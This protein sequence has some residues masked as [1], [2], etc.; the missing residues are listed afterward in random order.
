MKALL[1]KPRGRFI[2][3]LR[4]VWLVRG[5]GLYAFGFIATFVLLELQSLA[6]DVLGIGSLF[7][8]QAVEFLVQFVLD[9]L[10]NTFRSFVW[11]VFILQIAPPFGAIALA[12]AFLW[13]ARFLKR[14]IETWLFP[15]GVP[16]SRKK[17]KSAL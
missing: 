11:P 13:F 7:N 17:K 5:G 2:E 4:K 8:G 12:L 15:D 3:W 9:S 16:E 1:D 6:D 14:P 10:S